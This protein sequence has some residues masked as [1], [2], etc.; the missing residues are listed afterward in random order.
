[1]TIKS[2]KNLAKVQI[3]TLIY[4]QSNQNWL[5]LGFNNGG[6]LGNLYTEICYTEMS[7]E[8]KQHLKVFQKIQNLSKIQES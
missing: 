8:L 3:C 4:E 2:H 7:T 5:F 1:M 6:C